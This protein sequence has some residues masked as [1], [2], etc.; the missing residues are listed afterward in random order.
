M[1]KGILLD[2]LDIGLSVVV[3]NAKKRG[4]EID[5]T[6]ALHHFRVTAQNFPTLHRIL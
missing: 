3:L 1:E 5:S 2:K 6:E 4:I